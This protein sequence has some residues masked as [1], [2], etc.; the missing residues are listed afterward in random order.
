MDID[1]LLAT[2]RDT[3]NVKRV[4]GEPIERDGTLVIP[5][6]VVIGGGGGGGRD[7]QPDQPGEGG[8]GFGV[9]ARPV[10]VY[11]VRDGRVDFRPAIDVAALALA[12]ALLTPCVL[13]AWPR[14]RRR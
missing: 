4:F 5:V 1:A 11:V 12:A 9:W 7:S 6:A 10:G 13:R 2:A 3:A 8:G 14:R